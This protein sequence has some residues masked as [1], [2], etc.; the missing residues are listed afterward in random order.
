MDPVL[1]Q[2]LNHSQQ[3]L[4]TLRA[5]HGALLGVAPLNNQLAIL[6]LSNP[7]SDQTIG[8]SVTLSDGTLSAS[9]GSLLAPK[10]TVQAAKD[11]TKGLLLGSANAGSRLFSSKADYEALDVASFLTGLVQGDGITITGTG[12][13]RTIASADRGSSQKIFGSVSDGTTDIAASTNADQLKLLQGAAVA[14]QYNAANKS[15]TFGLRLNFSAL[16]KATDDANGVRSITFENVAAGKVLCGPASGADA[17]PGFRNL[18]PADFGDAVAGNTFLAGPS[19]SA[20][21]VGSFRGIAP[22]D[23]PKATTTNVGGVKIG[24]GL[25]IAADGTV[26]AD[27]SAISGAINLWKTLKVGA[28]TLAA[29]SPSD[30]FEFTKSGPVV[31]TLNTAAKTLTIGM[32][33]ASTSQDGYLSQGDFTTF[34]GYAATLLA[35]QNTVNGKA[36]AAATTASLNEKAAKA[37]DTITGRYHFKT[38]GDSYG[39]SV[40]RA[41]AK[42]WQLRSN[43]NGADAAEDNSAPSWSLALGESGSD[44]VAIYR[45]AAGS[46]AWTKLFS[47]T[48]AGTAVVPSLNSGDITP[49]THQGRNM[50]F[51]NV[52]W[53]Q[54]VS[55]TL[56]SSDGNVSSYSDGRTKSEVR[57]IEFGLDFVR[58]LR[59]VS[60]RLDKKKMSAILKTEYNGKEDARR[61]LG[62]IAQDVEAFLSQ[63]GFDVVS[64][65]PD[66]RSDILSLNYQALIAPIIRAVQ[67]LAVR[68]EALEVK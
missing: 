6:L 59:P 65:M 22:A 3:P 26:S 9:E 38:S 39:F 32:G 29:A 28:T 12:H 35:L 51:S 44:N 47:I 4:S 14:L 42:N 61:K 19:A 33:A 49:N 8:K 67:E 46:G 5:V 57:D 18:V 52:A 45:R 36:D 1:G 7:G 68:V 34:A 50:G 56:Y 20:S 31:L 54:V 63:T 66:G 16:F 58:K 30:T 53:G 15:I 62:L 13:Q 60:Y 25:S 27:Q 23:L 40:V 48:N 55:Q 21:G 43:D 41:A 10:G 37:G 24:G 11:N 2:L 17:V 64:K